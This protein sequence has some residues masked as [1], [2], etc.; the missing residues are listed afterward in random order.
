M[1]ES[2]YLLGSKTLKI[3]WG[4][5]DSEIFWK[6]IRFLCIYM[7]YTAGS[8]KWWFC[9]AFSISLIE[10]REKKIGF[11]AILRIISD[12]WTNKRI[13]YLPKIFGKRAAFYI[14]K[15]L[16]T[17]E[18]LQTSVKE[19]FI[20]IV[21][22]QRYSISIDYIDQVLCVSKTWAPIFSIS[23]YGRFD[24]PWVVQVGGK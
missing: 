11:T 3:N 8:W 7:H 20:R 22:L 1:I 6:K 23:F 17:D 16:K 15:I 18:I 24:C 12:F 14:L 4:K 13:F 19:G 5:K 9:V 10:V 2:A 21:M